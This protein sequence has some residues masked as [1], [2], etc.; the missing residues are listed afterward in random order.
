MKR[1]STSYVIRKTQNNNNL[2]Q[3]V[4]NL[5]AMQEPGFRL[6]IWKIL[7]RRGQLPTPVFWPGE[8]HGLYGSRGHKESDKTAT[9]TLASL[10]AQTVKNLPAMWQTWVRSLG[11]EDPLEKEVAVHSSI[12]AW[13]IP[14]TEKPCGL[15]SMGSQRV[16]HNWATKHKIQDAPIRKAQIQ[17]TDSTKCRW[18]C[19]ATGALS[20]MEIQHAT[21]TL[22]ECLEVSYKTKLNIIMWSSSLVFPNELKP[23]IYTKT[24]TWIVIEASFVAAKT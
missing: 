17:N 19:E 3:T 6:W 21:A 15:Q 10:V 18:G 9:F 5:C 23:N 1:W 7:W 14:W 13:E 2:A 4:S 22:E 20:L 16:G 11:R 12:L 24:R 8:F